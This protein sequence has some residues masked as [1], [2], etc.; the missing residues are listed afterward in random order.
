MLLCRLL[1]VHLRRV[2]ARDT[3]DMYLAKPPTRPRPKQ[4]PGSSLAPAR[5]SLASPVHGGTMAAD[6]TK[7]DQV[8]LLAQDAAAVLP[9]AAPELGE[10]GRGGNAHVA[11]RG[12]WKFRS[13]ERLAD[14]AEGRLGRSLS[15]KR[16]QGSAAQNRM[17]APRLGPPGARRSKGLRPPGDQGR[18]HRRRQRK[19]RGQWTGFERR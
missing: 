5:S 19:S 16:S 3:L 1:A 6:A 9:L 4:L 8:D 11:V 17:A 15:G 13:N 10:E 7:L 2:L 14:A 18:R 12:A